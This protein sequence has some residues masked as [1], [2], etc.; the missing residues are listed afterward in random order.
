[1]VAATLRLGGVCLGALLGQRSLSVRS[2]QPPRSKPASG[3]HLTLSSCGHRDF[4]GSLPLASSLTFFFF[5]FLFEVWPTCGQEDGVDTSTM[6]SHS[7][8][9]R[10]HF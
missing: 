2:Y 6:W 4:R 5:F 10:H 1:M 8:S 7:L 9:L 3:W